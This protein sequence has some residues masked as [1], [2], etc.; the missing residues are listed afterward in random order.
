VDLLPPIETYHPEIAQPDDY[1]PYE[2]S[3]MAQIAGGNT[4]RLVTNLRVAT[5]MLEVFQ[6]VLDGT[7]QVEEV[8]VDTAFAPFGDPTGVCGPA[9]RSIRR[10]DLS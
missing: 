1:A 10:V 4:Q 7:L 8:V 9:T 6:G 2:E 3:C 5:A